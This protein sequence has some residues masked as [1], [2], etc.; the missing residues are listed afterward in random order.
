MVRDLSP[1][2]W[3]APGTASVSSL[4]T[5]SNVSNNPLPQDV[6]IS[7]Y[8]YPKM[9]LV[10]LTASTPLTVTLPSTNVR[11]VK[12]IP[13]RGNAVAITLKGV[14]GDTGIGINPNGFIE[15]TPVSGLASFVLLPG[16]T[17]VSGVEVIWW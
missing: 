7:N 11:Y 15:F 14:S 1:S 8:A 3:N 13:P 5:L 4:V 12:V 2:S 17:N 16:A 6:W 10:D 9:T